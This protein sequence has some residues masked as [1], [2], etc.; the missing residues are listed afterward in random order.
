MVSQ[1]L[2]PTFLF[3]SDEPASLNLSSLL[4]VP[5]FVLLPHPLKVFLNLCATFSGQG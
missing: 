2:F 5:A 3:M 4:P 1:S